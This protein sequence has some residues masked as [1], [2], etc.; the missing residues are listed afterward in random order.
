VLRMEPQGSTRETSGLCELFVYSVFF[1]A[2]FGCQNDTLKFC[3]DTLNS[4]SPDIVLPCI[5]IK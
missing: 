3:N 4:D 5:E 2:V 1:K